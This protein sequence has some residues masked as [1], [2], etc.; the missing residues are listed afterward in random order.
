ME[1]FQKGDR[2][3]LKESLGPL[4]EKDFG[5]V[6]EVYRDSVI[7]FDG[8]EVAGTKDFEDHSSGLAALFDYAVLAVRLYRG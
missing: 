5:L 6:V 4:T 8:A 2:V 3:A 7:E 1:S